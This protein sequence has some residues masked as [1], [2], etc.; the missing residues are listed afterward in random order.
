M[1]TSKHTI[2]QK[3]IAIIFVL[4]I[5]IPAII[6]WA[7]AILANTLFNVRSSYT[8]AAIGIIESIY[9]ATAVYVIVGYYIV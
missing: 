9:V 7:G 3:I 4:V 2:D 6:Y 8:G 5:L 1:Y